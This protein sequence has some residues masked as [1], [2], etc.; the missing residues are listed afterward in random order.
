MIESGL[1]AFSHTFMVISGQ[2]RNPGPGHNVLLLLI[3]PKGTFSCQNHIQSHTTLYIYIVTKPPTQV[4]H[5]QV[6][7]RDTHPSTGRSQCCLTS[8][9]KGTGVS[10]LL[11]RMARFIRKNL[12]M[13]NVPYNEP[14]MKLYFSIPIPFVL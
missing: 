10:T 3:G 13:Y 4:I 1:M 7:W 11:G 6:T 8:V 5:R 14:I 2:G 9:I 12:S